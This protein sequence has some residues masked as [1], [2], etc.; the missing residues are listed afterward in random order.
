MSIELYFKGDFM[1]FNSYTSRF[2]LFAPKLHMSFKA[3]R[4]DDE[5][6]NTAAKAVGF[7]KSIVELDLSKGLPDPDWGDEETPITSASY[8][9]QEKGK[10]LRELAKAAKDPFTI[11]NM[12]YVSELNVEI[13]R[14]DALKGK[15]LFIYLSKESLTGPKGQLL[16]KYGY[17]RE[18][19]LNGL[20]HFPEISSKQDNFN[21]TYLHPGEYFVTVVVDNGDFIPG[22]GDISLTS[23]KVIVKPESQQ[24]LRMNSQ[25][26]H[27]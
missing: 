9:W 1:E 15:K 21:F 23:Q 20:M 18:D 22:S 26:V 5:M 24:T 17:V 2:G 27:N 16:V 13:D 12:P 6:M 4:H 10:T 8:M 14:K 25:A 3:K 19:L 7:P 11:V